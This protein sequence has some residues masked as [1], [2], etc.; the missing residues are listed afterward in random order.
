MYE[1]GQ[2][3]AVAW[4]NNY[5]LKGECLSHSAIHPQGIC[6]MNF[7]VILLNTTEDVKA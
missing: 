7:S 3:V 1:L 6:M 4:P 2:Q 5:I